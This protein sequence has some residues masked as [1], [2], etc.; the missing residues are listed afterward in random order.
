M[1]LFLVGYSQR[2]AASQLLTEGVL[3]HFTVFG[4]A[5]QRK[6]AR[7]LTVRYTTATGR[8]VERI[9]NHRYMF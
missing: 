8:Y 6:T 4:A 5:H 7:R 9:R 2:D 1:I 3:N